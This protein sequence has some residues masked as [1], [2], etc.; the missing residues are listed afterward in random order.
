MR[1][2]M[3]ISLISLY[4]LGLLRPVA[5]YIEFELNKGYIQEFLCI[6]KEQPI[7]VCGG[8]CYLTKQL[9]EAA[10]DQKS[11]PTQ[12]INL[13]DYPIGFVSIFDTT[14]LS[15]DRITHYFQYT[16]KKTGLFHFDI[17]H[18]PLT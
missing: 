1:K 11:M 4:F 12:L 8:K 16:I 3:T 17:F 2:W 9:K 7:T 6:K 18:P 14:D 15:G 10:E 5:P 13:E